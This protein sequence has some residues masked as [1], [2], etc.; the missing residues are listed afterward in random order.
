DEILPP[1]SGAASSNLK[2]TTYITTYTKYIA[3]HSETL[4]V[5]NDDGDPTPTVKSVYP[6]TVVIIRRV[7]A[8][9][10]QETGSSNI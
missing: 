8:A 2:Y 10:V 5:T 7:T 9:L 1:P 4:T 6:T 3:G